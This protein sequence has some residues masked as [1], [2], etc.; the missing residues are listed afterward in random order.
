MPDEPAAK[1]RIY[2]SVFFCQDVVREHNNLITAVRIGN[3]YTVP[4]TN[5]TVELGPGVTISKQV[6]LPVTI[7]AVVTF[8]SDGPVDFEVLLKGFD[9]D[10]SPITFGEPFQCHS[11]GGY[12]GHVL[13]T[14]IVVG[15]RKQG[16]HRIDVYVDGIV[17]TKLFFLVKHVGIESDDPQPGPPVPS[18][19]VSE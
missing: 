16:E 12:S 1:P 9:P 6:W 14:R 7:S 17:A 11:E 8:S 3:L 18:P 10:G 2:S 15:T 13:N 4:P 19:G 5:V